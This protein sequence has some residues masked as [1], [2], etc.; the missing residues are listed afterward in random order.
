MAL[1]YAIPGMVVAHA[2][3]FHWIDPAEAAL[4]QALVHLFEA[5]VK[6]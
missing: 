5:A 2:L 3:Y 1:G 6:Q 4:G